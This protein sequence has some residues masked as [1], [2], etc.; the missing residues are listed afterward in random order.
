MASA[1]I[2]RSL[3][4]A[5]DALEA[6]RLKRALKHAW[7]AGLPAT[8]R[9]DAGSLRDVI[10]VGAAIRDRASDRHADVAAALVA[11]CTEALENPRPR[12]GLLARSRPGDATVDRDTKTCPACAETI[13]AAARV[14][15]FCGHGLETIA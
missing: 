5:R 2:S 14:C 13:K 3:E 8:S 4:Q 1:R 7:Q 11:Y 15:R 10:A 6:G 12:R 9:N